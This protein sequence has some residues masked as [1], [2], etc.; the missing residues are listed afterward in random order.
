MAMECNG[1][2]WRGFGPSVTEYQQREVLGDEHL[3]LSSPL[4]SSPLLSSPLLSFT[5]SDS[6]LLAKKGSEY[7][8]WGHVSLKYF[9]VL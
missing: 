2:S 8:F 1:T 5:C 6:F 9:V 7:N 4:L 3:A